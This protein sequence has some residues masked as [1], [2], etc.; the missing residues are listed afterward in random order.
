VTT[1]NPTGNAQQAPGLP[2]A[3]KPTL[4]GN[5]PRPNTP[6]T[7]PSPTPP[8]RPG[9]PNN[10]FGGRAP[11]R[12]TWEIVP[13]Q[14]GVVRFELGHIGVAIFELAGLPYPDPDPLVQPSPPAP[15]PTGEGGQENIKQKL[16]TLKPP[17]PPPPSPSALIAHAFV[18]ALN[19][20]PEVEARLKEILDAAWE[21]YGMVG[22]ALIHGWRIEARE[23]Y[24]TRLAAV[25]LPPNYLRASDPVFVLN[26]LAR[27]RSTVLLSNAP[28]ALERGFLERSLFCDDARIVALAQ[29]LGTPEAPLVEPPPP[30]EGDELG[31]EE[32]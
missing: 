14:D 22:A 11:G 4:S 23:A 5:L 20:Q 2:G 29:A 31:D 1:Q 13:L 7:P 6:A 12:V 32:N 28:L 17:Q 18:T 8:Q 30:S 10:L 9:L 27:A 15:P 16:G 24:A 25:N 19:A 26:V 21:S 3:A